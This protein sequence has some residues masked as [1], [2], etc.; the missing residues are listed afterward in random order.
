VS[1]RATLERLADRARA[2]VLAGLA[3]AAGLAGLAI[4]GGSAAAAPA[5][6]R[7]GAPLELSFAAFNGR[8]SEPGAALGV[9]EQGPLTLRLAS[10]DNALEVLEHRVRLRPLG[11]GSHRAE[12]TAAV[13]G[14]G[15]L[16][17]DLSVSGGQP[18]RL[19]DEVT[20]PAQS[21]AVEGRV[22]LAPGLEGYRVVPLELPEAVHLEVE[23]AL[24]GRLVTLCTGFTLLVPGGADCRGLGRALSRVAVP[25]P[26]PG[27]ELLLPY[28][29]LGPAERDRLD[30]YL[31]QVATP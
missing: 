31:A 1:G 2:A 19:V 9:V 26:A 12:L 5:A 30:R 21:I 28:A 27:D 16:I 3:V 10:P 6:D 8:F 23:S 7:G 13:R 24:A 22:R 25:L 18:G 20:L 15:R 17:A 29:A 4:A 14:R 11:D